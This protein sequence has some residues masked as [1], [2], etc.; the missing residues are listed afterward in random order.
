M[1]VNLVMLEAKP[2]CIEEMKA[3]CTYNHENSVKEEGNV[4][5]DVLQNAEDPCK[6]TLYEVF[7]NKEAIEF[8]KNTEHYKRWAQAM[9]HILAAPRYKISNTDVAFTK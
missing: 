8:H 4:R 3:I 2:E 5:F 7:E 9:E 1:I 6:F